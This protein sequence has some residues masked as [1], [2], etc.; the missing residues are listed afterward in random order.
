MPLEMRRKMNKVIITD[1]DHNNIDIERKM[2]SDA[3]VEL[4]LLQCHSEDELIESCRGVGVFINQYAPISER[5]ISSLTDMKMVVR[6]GVGVNNIDVAAAQ[7]LGVQVC[8]V[9]DYGISEVADHAVAL[10]M[11]LVRKLPR[12]DKHTKTAKWD[13]SKAVPIKR[14]S[15]CVVGVVGLG[16]IGRAYASRMCAMGCTIIGVDPFYKP[17]QKDGTAYISLVTMDELIEQADIISLHCPLEGNRDLIGAKEFKKMK[18]TAF[19]INT[20]RGGIINELHLRDALEQGEI[21]GAGL[22]V[23]DKEPMATASPIFMQENI[24]CTPHMAWYS[25]EA[26]QDLKRKAA[27]EALRFLRGEAVKYPVNHIE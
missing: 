17:C 8:N 26:A 18:N 24:I 15:D 19:I 25:E 21:G 10:T 23:F 5:V 9:P 6:Y 4:E 27:E 13:Y 3:G 11:A 12:M 14:L 2:F 16:R 7:K 20:T 1:C 22:D